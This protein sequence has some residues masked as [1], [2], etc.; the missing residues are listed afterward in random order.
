[1]EYKKSTEQE[2]KI[3]I[4]GEDTPDKIAPKMKQ[5]AITS[6]FSTQKRKKE[7]LGL[8][9]GGAGARGPPTTNVKKQTQEEP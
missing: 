6:Y 4:G 7:P 5:G 8:A 3:E 2:L 9:G 1:M